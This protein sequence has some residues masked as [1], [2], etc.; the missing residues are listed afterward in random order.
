MKRVHHY[1][2]S[3]LKSIQL[4]L[5]VSFISLPFLIG[6][7]LPISVLSPI[8]TLMFGPFLTCFLLISSLIFFLELFYVPNSFFIWCL[9]H[10]THIWL[11]CLNMEQRT[12][13]LSFS[14]P[15]YIILLF[16]PCIALIIIHSKK[17][18]NTSLRTSILAFFLMLVCITLKFFPY[19]CPSTM[20][21]KIPCNKGEITLINHNNILILS[22]TH[23]LAARPSYESFIAYTLVPKIIEK[24]GCMHIDHLMVNKLNKR[25]FD[26]L[27]FLAT[28]IDIKNLYMPAWKGKIPL[29]AWRSYVKLKKTITD[30][31]GKLVAIYRKKQLYLDDTYTLALTPVATKDIHYYD[32]TYQPLSHYHLMT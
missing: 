9:E 16:I 31:N 2:H 19:H 18:T 22:D 32:A 10:V 23:L 14:K 3:F 5:F 27:Q 7:G 21:T 20:T 12:W 15:S 1:Y 13:L 26:A 28:K 4:Q 24:T 8:S 11:I 30:N 25:I 6:W 29:F 17:I